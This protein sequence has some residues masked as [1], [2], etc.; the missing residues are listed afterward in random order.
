MEQAKINGLEATDL[1]ITGELETDQVTGYQSVENVLSANEI[2]YD[3]PDI[4]LEHL[5]QQ[6]NEFFAQLENETL[7]QANSIYQSEEA[8][9][10]HIVESH[11]FTDSQ[12][13]IVNTDFGAEIKKQELETN[14]MSV[15]EKTAF[16][17][18]L[19]EV[20]GE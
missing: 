14:K 10:P 11:S 19:A 13:M 1:E 7:V 17:A 8:V 2:D 18:L 15:D 4:Y 3:A 12:N 20:R 5:D 16:D 6:T 9:M